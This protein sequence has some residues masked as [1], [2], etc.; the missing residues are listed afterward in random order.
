MGKIEVKRRPPTTWEREPIIMNTARVAILL[1][2]HEVQ[3]RRYAE[4][5]KIP[6]FKVGGRWRFEKTQLMKFAG[7]QGQVE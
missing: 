2:I 7:V 4:E 3:V 5:G 6:A 1:G